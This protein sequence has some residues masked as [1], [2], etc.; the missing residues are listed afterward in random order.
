MCLDEISYANLPD[1]LLALDDVQCEVI[2]VA[3]G[4]TRVATIHDLD[5]E[6]R[7]HGENQIGRIAFGTIE[8]R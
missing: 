5:I 2:C 1:R 4:H 8:Y 6:Y 7:M 3:C